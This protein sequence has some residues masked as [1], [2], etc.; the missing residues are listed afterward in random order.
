[1]NFEDWEEIL[2]Q[3]NL[4]DVLTETD[5]NED[6]SVA[7]PLTIKEIREIANVLKR[8][9]KDN[10]NH[11]DN[12]K[13]YHSNSSDTGIVSNHPLIGNAVVIKNTKTGEFRYLPLNR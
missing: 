4:D 1:M 12:W 2:E 3:N 11:I 7:I 8:R 10:L 13:V 5:Y 6:Y 9:K